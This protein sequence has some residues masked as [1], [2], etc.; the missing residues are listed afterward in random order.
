MMGIPPWPEFIREHCYNAQ[1][2]PELQELH[3]GIAAKA[4]AGRKATF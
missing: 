3:P 1:K 4:P 2:D